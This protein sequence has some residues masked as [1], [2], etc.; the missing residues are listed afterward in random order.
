MLNMNMEITM[1]EVHVFDSTLV[2]AGNDKES[3]NHFEL[4]LGKANSKKLL[5][6]LKTGKAHSCI[7]LPARVTFGKEEY[8]GD[9]RFVVYDCAMMFESEDGDMCFVRNADS[10]SNDSMFR[11]ILNRLEQKLSSSP[12]EMMRKVL[13]DSTLREEFDMYMSIH[14]VETSSL[15]DLM[16]GF[17]EF[18][19]R[20]N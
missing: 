1:L 16:K 17:I 7:S 3:H 8:F 2:V 6:F 14:E 4:K 12:L 19:K 5:N 20:R 10:I 18:R 13:S 9:S 11:L 15:D